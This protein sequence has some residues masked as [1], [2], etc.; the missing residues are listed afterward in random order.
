MGDGNSK[1]GSD[2]KSRTPSAPPHPAPVTRL[3]PCCCPL[4][5][6]LEAAPRAE[7]QGRRGDRT[8]DRSLAPCASFQVWGQGT[9]AHFS[10]HLLPPRMKRATLRPQQGCRTEPMGGGGAA[11]ACRTT[12]LSWASEEEWPGLA[13]KRGRT[14]LARG[15]PAQERRAGQL[16]LP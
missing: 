10:K 7:S 9:L 3:T 1:K 12:A 15:Q 2:T 11:A 4:A 8:R 13:D 5:G 16:T 14:G 6:P